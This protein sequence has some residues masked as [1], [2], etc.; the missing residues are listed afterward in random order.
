MESFWR[1]L[2]EI[3]NRASGIYPGF[4]LLTCHCNSKVI[5]PGRQPLFDFHVMAAEMCQFACILAELVRMYCVDI[6][7]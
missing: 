4:K 5:S 2:R 7:S 1:G 3:P 6:S